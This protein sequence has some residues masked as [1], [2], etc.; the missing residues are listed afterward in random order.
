MHVSANR[1]RNPAPRAQGPR[2][3]IS[4]KPSPDLRVFRIVSKISRQGIRQYIDGLLG[5]R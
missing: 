1:L 4:P 2:R 3:G 5:P